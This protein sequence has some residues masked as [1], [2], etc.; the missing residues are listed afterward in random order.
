[1]AS[2]G[3]FRLQVLAVFPHT[4][5]DRLRPHTC[6]WQHSPSRFPHIRPPL[7]QHSHRQ[8][9]PLSS[10]TRSLWPGHRPLHTASLWHRPLRIAL[11][12]ATSHTASTSGTQSLWHRPLHI[13]SLRCRSLHSIVSA[14]ATSHSI[15]LASAT[16]HSIALASATSHTVST[17]GTQLLWHRLLHISSLRCQSL[18]SIV[19]ASATS[20]SIALASAT[21]HTVTVALATSHTIASALVTSHHRVGIGHFV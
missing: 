21:L 11:A 18:H 3:S 12:S 16:S 5:P 20:H 2:C 19:L 7:M 10:S 17:S 9:P 8:S 1:M 14:S 6:S 15:A 4:V 13:P